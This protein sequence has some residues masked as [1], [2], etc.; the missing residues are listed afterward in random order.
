[1]SVSAAAT[2]PIELRKRTPRWTPSPK[3]DAQTFQNLQIENRHLRERL[4]AK[5]QPTST[6]TKVVKYIALGTL[7]AAALATAHFT[8]NPA[9]LK[10]VLKSITIPDFIKPYIPD[11]IT[12]FFTE[13]I[14]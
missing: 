11:S 8:G 1:M 7:A 4:L 5:E 2:P 12:V 10:P 13:F 3:G 14:K 9:P 6:A